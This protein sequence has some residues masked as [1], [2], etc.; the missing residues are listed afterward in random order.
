[1]SQFKNR[2][3]CEES[4]FYSHTVDPQVPNASGVITVSNGHT[5]NKAVADQTFTLSTLTQSNH[6]Q[7]KG[8]VVAV[9]IAP[10]GAVNIPVSLNIN[11]V[12]V[13]T[14]QVIQDQQNLINEL[15]AQIQDLQAY[16]NKL[17]TFMTAFS[18]GIYLEGTSGQEFDYGELVG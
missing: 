16:I 8:Q 18:Q 4:P 5:A 14:N 6:F 10:N 17:K 9:D 11:G 12:P 2:L 7:I 13:Q 1:M 3:Y 15:Q